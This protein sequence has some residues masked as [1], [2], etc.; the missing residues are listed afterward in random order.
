MNDVKAMLID[1]VLD[2]FAIAQP[3]GMLTY[4]DFFGGLGFWIDGKIFAAYL[5][6]GLALKLA[7]DDRAHLLSQGGSPAMYFHEYVE[8][9]RPML[10]DPAQ[11]AEWIEKSIAYSTRVKS[12]S[13]KR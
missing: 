2:A 8:V 12:K 3:D 9:P 1:A 11:L 10:D 5:G 6:E 4:K 7:P 13:K